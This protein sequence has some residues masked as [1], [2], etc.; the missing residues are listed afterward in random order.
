MQGVE[1]LKLLIRKSIFNELCCQRAHGLHTI[2]SSLMYQLSYASY[3]HDGEMYYMFLENFLFLL[4]KI[5]KAYIFLLFYTEEFN[6][7]CLTFD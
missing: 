1:L 7:I 2:M 4:Q 6:L 5:I 3:T